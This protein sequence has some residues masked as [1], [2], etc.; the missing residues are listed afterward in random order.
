[1]LDV[2]KK[3][4]D[5][6]TGAERIEDA[7]QIKTLRGMLRIEP[8]RKD[9]V[10]IRYT[11]REEFLNTRGI[12]IDID[13][14]Y[15]EWDYEEQDDKII[16][17]TGALYLHISK[18]DAAICY[19]DQE[20]AL[21]LA[22]RAKDPRELESFDSMKIK[23][24]A[25]VEIEEIATADGIKKRIRKAEKEFDKQLYHTRLHLDF[26]KD[27]AIY[28]LGQSEEGMLN[29]RGTTQ[30]VHQANR[31]IA[32][33]F[34][35]S[36][37]G[38]GILWSTGSPM[39][40]Q[41]TQFGSYVY[42]EADLEMDYYLIQGQNFD[43]I[44]SG[45]RYLTGKAVMLP[46]WAFGYVQSQE[47]YVDQKEILGTVDEYR[48]RGIGLDCIVLDWRS[49]YDGMWGQKTFDL[50]R[51]PD[52]Q[53][54]TDELHDKGV[55]FM[56]SIWPN[57][58]EKTDNYREF[59]ENHLLIPTN[60]IYDAFRKEARELYWKQANEGIF[61]YG[62]DAWW[63][64][65][66]EPFTP[67]WARKERPEPS[68]L[69][70][71]YVQAA[72]NYLP[73]EV[74][75]A[76]GLVH[77]QGI[78][79]GQRSSGSEKRVMNLTRSGYTGQQR[80][81]T[82]LWSGDI[83]ASWKTYRDQIAVGLNFCVSGLPYWTLDIGAFFVKRGMPWFWTGDYEEGMDDLGYQEL[84][85]RWFQYGAF[86]PIF[87]AHGTDIRREMWAVDGPDH[88]FYNALVEANRLRYRLMPYIYSAAGAVWKED[89]TIMRM[90]AFD[91]AK[92]PVAREIKDQYLFGK[93]MMISPV[94]EP[95]YFEVNSQ[96]II[97][98]KVRNVYLPEGNDWYDFY[99]GARY[100]GGQTIQVECPIDR[101]PIHVKAG[102]I[103]PT[104]KS[105]DHNADA[106]V[107]GAVELLVYPGKDAEFAL[108]EDAGN[109]YGYEKGEYALTIMKWNE[110]E[111]KLQIE[112]PV[113][114]IGWM[115]KS[116]EYT[117]TVC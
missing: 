4:R 3:Q 35:V 28:G 59:M 17:R 89:A 45:Y 65:S 48:R 73:A 99:T 66:S 11:R 81:G 109:G 29:L 8:K 16:V 20:N 106:S 30:Y 100:E 77:A 86:L 37:K 87:R 103:I 13:P 62:T 54:M 56:V 7:L 21:L 115:P 68:A 108:Y 72:S 34:I 6:I 23:D 41:D 91:Y 58:D 75:N 112:K 55:A 63:C 51:F 69:F 47:R 102:S 61:S 94:T 116:H 113:S 25:K 36:T 49:W 92:D 22:E 43:A 46:R 31:K 111:Q 93:N 12:G 53:G 76:F 32:V 71:D 114:P 24:G 98:D 1:M 117:V 79:E 105:M 82:V 80:Y 33:P 104:S 14:V 27:E 78:Y 96:P 26:Q 5:Q 2:Y 110:K 74:T 9:I 50:T 44:I 64:D 15:K 42:T 10:R 101:I 57:M 85:T 90:L 84:Y 107:K 52:L 40:F 38:Y 60:N 83:D 19:Y 67:E 97:R 88:C 70:Q 95:M 39:I 18:S